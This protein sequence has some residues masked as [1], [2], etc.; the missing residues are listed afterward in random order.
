MS[1]LSNVG[2]FAGNLLGLGIRRKV[3]QYFDRDDLKHRYGTMRG[4]GFTHGEMA[5]G[6][7][8]AT[9]GNGP[10]LAQQERLGV[11][12][13]MQERQHAHEQRL[14]DKDV[15]VATAGQGVT[16][17]GQD[18]DETLRA[19]ANAIS[20][21]AY[22]NLDARERS[23]I[24]REWQTFRIARERG[25][26]EA[27]TQSA[28][29]ILHRALLGMGPENLRASFLAIQFKQE[30]IDLVS[31]DGQVISKADLK[32]VLDKLRAEGSTLYRELTGIGAAVDSIA[33]GITGPGAPDIPQQKGLGRSLHERE[34]EMFDK[35]MRGPEFRR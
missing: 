15:A 24:E 16:R 33:E 23:R 34:N 30:G 4:L 35:L 19:E 5:G 11:E 9:L 8:T 20:R 26:R 13:E 12:R 6:A 31:P 3:E 18:I 27:V 1:F 28:S 32:R 10:Q 17:R 29:F 2:R 14:K 22:Q 7:G 25:D 21:A